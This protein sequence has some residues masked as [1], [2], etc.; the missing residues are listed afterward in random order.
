L[1]AGRRGKLSARFLG[2][3]VF[4]KLNISDFNVKFLKLAYIKISK[5]SKTI[6]KQSILS[7]TVFWRSVGNGF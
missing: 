4:D 3:V 6:K 5:S 7:N 1:N 2:F